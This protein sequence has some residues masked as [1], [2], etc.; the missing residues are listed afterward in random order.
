MVRRIVEIDVEKVIEKQDLLLSSY[1][2]SILRELVEILEPFE[3]ATDMLQGEL[4][5]SISLAIPCF[6]GL[7]DHLTKFNIQ[8]CNNLVR[9]LKSSLGRR[10]DYVIDDPLYVCG[11]ML[12]SRLV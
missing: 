2:K 1:E 12:N 9:T 10:L 6:L 11:A 4:Y 5:N 3:D 7:K 8:H